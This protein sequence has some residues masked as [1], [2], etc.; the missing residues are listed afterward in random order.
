MKKSTMCSVWESSN[1]KL[2]PHLH[3]R[4]LSNIN[5]DESIDLFDVKKY[6]ARADGHTD[7]SKA[8]SA[9]WNSACSS[10]KH[11]VVHIPGGEYLLHPVAFKGPCE[12]HN[13]TVQVV[14]N[15]IASRENRLWNDQGLD[16]WLHF[17]DVNGLTVE[18]GGSLHGNGEFWWNESCSVNKMNSL[19]FSRGTN[20]VVRNISSISSRQIHISFDS[21]NG[22][23]ANELRIHAP[24]SSPNTDGI[25]LQRSSNVIIRDIVVGTGDD[26]ISMGAGSTNISIAHIRCGPGHGISVGSLGRNH[27]AAAVSNVHV[28][29]VYLFNTK[30]GLRIKTWQGGR[31][32]ATGFTFTNVEMRNVENPIFIDQFYCPHS[33]NC[34]NQT[35]AVK[36]SKVW[37][38]NIHGTSATKVAV[39]FRCSQAVPCHEITLQNVFLNY[40]KMSDHD[41]GDEYVGDN[42]LSVCQNAEGNTRGIVNP[43]SCLSNSIRT[44]SSN[45]SLYSLSQNYNSINI[46]RRRLEEKPMDLHG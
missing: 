40:V 24:G 38:K 27:E 28:S 4:K 1:R 17:K 2:R 36:I 39:K 5:T 46:H 10:S 18:G 13:I 37:Y 9:A 44:V 6:G 41:G 25:H 33:S 20:I 45:S 35:S 15:L 34:A 7:S 16:Y 12:A 42:A 14:G 32:S 21:C 30:N 23:T 29:D 8:F 43:P 11:S 22:V 31:G 3:E 26:C 19:K